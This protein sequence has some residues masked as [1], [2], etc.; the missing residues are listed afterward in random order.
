[1]TREQQLKALHILNH[2]K[3]KNQYLKCVEELS[4]LS[5]AIM[6]HVNKGGYEAEVFEEVVDVL[7]M[8]E[9]IKNCLPYGPNQFETEISRK[10]DR[11]LERMRNA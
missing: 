1:M 10:L 9:Q 4:E 8:L 5:T 11:Q 7:I 6:Q 2:Y 3:P